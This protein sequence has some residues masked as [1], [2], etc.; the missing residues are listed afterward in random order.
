MKVPVRRPRYPMP[1][2][3]K[4]ALEDSKLYETYKVRP[5]YQQNDYIAWINR[6]V[7]EQT[8]Q[9]RIKQMLMELKKGDVYMKMDWKIKKK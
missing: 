8:K 3:I 6:A 7:Q 4:Q 9:K 2:Y 1:A 5:P